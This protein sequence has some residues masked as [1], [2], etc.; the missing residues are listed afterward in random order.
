M[1]EMSA[2]GEVRRRLRILGVGLIL[3]AGLSIFAGVAHGKL[4][5]KTFS[6]G[7]INRAIPDKA[8]IF[9]TAIASPIVVK[10]WGRVRSV[11]VAVRITHPDTGDLYL[12]ANN[13]QIKASVL[14]DRVPA[15]AAGPGNGADF[16]SGA[17]ACAGS[18]FTVFNDAAPT[19][20]LEGVNPFAGAFRPITPLTALR[21]GQMH[22]KWFLEVQDQAAGDAGVINCWRVKIRYKPQRPPRGAKSPGDRPP[23]GIK[24]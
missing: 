4:R 3:A 23:D 21:G 13:P 24:T 11:K 8:G 17:P 14:A 19:S 5:T 10:A 18:A 22:G 15:A 7:N 9:E 2:G 12:E 6:S 1:T 20:I 16:G